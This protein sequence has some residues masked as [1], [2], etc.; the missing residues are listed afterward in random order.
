[1]DF[2]HLASAFENPFRT[3]AGEQQQKSL[4]KRKRGNSTGNLTVKDHGVLPTE[5]VYTDD[6]ATEGARRTTF[7]SPSGT[8]L[9]QQHYKVLTG[10]LHRCL[11]D[12]DYPRASR[13]WGMLLRLEIS[14]HPLDIRTQDRWGIGAELLLH[15][16]PGPID[17]SI[18][19]E[20]RLRN[21]DDREPSHGTRSLQSGLE[22]AKD[23]YERLILQ[24]PYRKTAP[25]STSSLTFY[26]VMFGIWIYS[27]QLRFKIAM[28][29]TQH[30][31]EHG[32]SP[33]RS[34]YD[35]DGNDELSE[36]SIIQTHTDDQV[37]IFKA[38][39]RDAEAVIERLTEL[40]SS[41]PYSDHAGL[42]RLRGMLYL[43]ISQLQYNAG[44]QEDSSNNSDDNLRSAAGLSRSSHLTGEPIT[45]TPDPSRPKIYDRN[46][47]ETIS[48]VK[49]SFERALKLGDPLDVQIRQEFGL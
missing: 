38:A 39:I 3:T 42:W 6:S 8:G 27:I 34:R 10:V 14:G 31:L 35:T 24:F 9:R 15:N 13:A 29:D 19:E 5:T 45:T 1:M 7:E 4:G 44:A 12:N 48:K 25:D 41:P 20:S 36:K 46:C 47:Q 32:S 21:R 2:P 23:Y 40:L 28:R 26:P 33:T 18:S 16:G 22:K 37:L 17:Q 43:W 30:D 11:L 49:E